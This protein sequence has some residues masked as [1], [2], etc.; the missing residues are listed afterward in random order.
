[1]GIWNRIKNYLSTLHHIFF[2]IWNRIKIKR[3]SYPISF[4]NPNSNTFYTTTIEQNLIQQNEELRQGLQQIQ[5]QLQQKEAEVIEQ[6]LL[7]K[8]QTSKIETLQQEKAVIEAK[9]QKKMKAAEV[10]KQNLAQYHKR[11]KET[12]TLRQQV[13]EIV[14]KGPKWLPHARQT[15]ISHILG[16]PPGRPGGGR[17]RPDLIH[18]SIDLVPRR[19]NECD[20]ILE[21]RPS[22]VVYDTVV[23]DLQRE[24]DEIGA[25][26]TLKMKNV[27]YRIHRKRCPKCNKWIYP[28]RGLLKNARFGIGVICYVISQRILLNQTYTDI[29]RDLQKIF[30]SNVSLSEPAIIDW[31]LKFED[32]IQAVY[33]QLEALVKDAEFL[34]IDR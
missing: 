8:A 12:R 11:K 2:R 26:D 25:Y 7:L 28:E 31:F 16:K 19:C 23:T 34:N 33:T 20:F 5:A 18:E 14:G 17:P 6:S 13:E 29:I 24:V 30:G 3:V 10:K 27:C 4:S 32:Q 1:M 22:Y 21:D 15:S 9:Y